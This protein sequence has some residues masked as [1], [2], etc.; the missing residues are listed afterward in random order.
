[1]ALRNLLNEGFHNPAL[2]PIEP[3]REFEPAHRA[4]QPE[5]PP[6]TLLAF[7]RLS[8]TAEQNRLA[9]MVL[10]DRARHL[11]VCVVTLEAGIG[12][13]DYG[14]GILFEMERDAIECAKDAWHYASQALE[15]DAQ[16]AMTFG[17]AVR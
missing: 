8:W 10:G 14:R 4:A 2:T 9:A 1:M 16:D 12:D 6:C 17:G 11:S 7:D 5:H 3:H 15:Q 13:S